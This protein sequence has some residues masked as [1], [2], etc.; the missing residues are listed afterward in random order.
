LRQT[1]QQAC[2]GFDYQNM[3][4]AEP[5]IR[6]LLKLD[7]EQKVK[8]TALRNFRQIINQTLNAYLLDFAHQQADHLLQQY[9][10]ARIYLAQTL[11]REAI[12][13]IRQI[14][15]QQ[16][17]LTENIETYNQAISAVNDCLIAMQLDR[18]Q[19]PLIAQTDLNA[20]PIPPASTEPSHSLLSPS[21][22]AELVQI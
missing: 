5:A 7:F 18:K 2:R 3:V 22:Q 6:Q 19:L 1:L 15:S 16:A 9:D 21:E 10:Q 11:E 17:A 14:H 20:G 13:K 8:D 4:D 12:D